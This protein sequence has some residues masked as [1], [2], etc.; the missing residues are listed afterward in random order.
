MAY[1]FSLTENMVV[2]QAIAP[3][4]GTGALL[5][6]TPISLK[7]CHKVWIVAHANTSAGADAV[8]VT[9]QQDTAVAFGAPAAFVTL[10]PHWIAADVATSPV[11]VREATDAINHAFAADLLNKT[12]VFEIDPASLTAGSDCIRVGMTAA[13][14][15][16]IAAEYIIEPR[17]PAGS[18]FRPNY[19]ID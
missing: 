3:Q 7:L 18:G 8:T 4:H 10:L 16:F 17:Y 11:L 13:A 14:G 9:P 12:C 6:G 19:L 15:S 2:I 5:G 1:P